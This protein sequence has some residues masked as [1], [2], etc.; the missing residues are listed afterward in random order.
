ML[1]IQEIGPICG[2]I[3]F[4][5]NSPGGMIKL[6]FFCSFAISCFFILSSLYV[7]KRDASDGEVNASSASTPASNVYNFSSAIWGVLAIMRSC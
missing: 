2:S 5:Q 3:V 1:V 7:L 6:Q 4:L